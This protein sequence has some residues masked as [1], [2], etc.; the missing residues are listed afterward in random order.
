MPPKRRSS[1]TSNDTDVP[2]PADGELAR[3]T[4]SKSLTSRR[5]SKVET[6]A[7]PEN[8]G[9]DFTFR[10]KSRSRASSIPLAS[11]NESS[12]PAPKKIDDAIKEEPNLLHPRIASLTGKPAKPVEMMVP[13][14]VEETPMIMRNKAMRNGDLKIP[15]KIGFDAPPAKGRRRSSLTMR[16]KRISSSSTGLSQMPHETIDPSEFYRH[17]DAEQSEPIRMRQLLIWCAKRAAP[18]I[19]IP[20]NPDI[21]AILEKAKEC[22]V[23][24]LIDKSINTSWYH[25]SDTNVESGNKKPN[26]RNVENAKKKAEQEFELERLLDEERRLKDL[27]DRRITS[28]QKQKQRFDTMIT[29]AKIES[30]LTYEQKAALTNLCAPALT[31]NR[32]QWMADVMEKLRIEMDESEFIAV[33]A[34]NDVEVSKTHCER[35]FRTWVQAFEDERKARQRVAEPMSL[36]RL[37]ATQEN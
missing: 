11:I 12:S 20:T 18:S 37:M 36:L 34:R 25:R 22:I 33:S 6:I 31:Q 23:Q 15:A 17:I 16:G 8:N 28:Q 1:S 26:P 2:G 14:S 7:D 9:D 19:S 32:G 35:L 30:M 13:V 5:A 3:R 10:R 29:P 24:G 27:L 4:K 21:N